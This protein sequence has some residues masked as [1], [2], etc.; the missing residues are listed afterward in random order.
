MTAL[1][2]TELWLIRHAESTGNRDGV[3]TGHR[4]LPLSLLGRHQAERLADRLRGQRF[5]AL[6]AS[7]LERARDTAQPVGIATGLG[8]ATDRR[9][10]EIDT[11]AWSGLTIA[12]I[13]ATFPE[14][15]ARWQQRDPDMRRGGGETTR[16][17]A[18]RIAGILTEIARA[19]A[20]ERVLIVAHGTIIR[21]A[22]ATILRLDFA[23]AWR[24]GVANASIARVRPFAHAG[25]APDTPEGMVFGVNDVTHLEE[26]HLAARR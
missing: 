25:G 7:D 19:H 3:I 1:G 5:A 9:L 26:A 2:R 8:V 11:G 18:A 6:Y 12:E 22:L 16:E 24:L 17:A 23:Q 10:R 13:Q 4:D 15:W 14:E 20:G 21:L